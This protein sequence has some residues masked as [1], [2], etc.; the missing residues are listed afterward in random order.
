MSDTANWQLAGLTSHISL[1]HRPYGPRIHL[2]DTAESAPAGIEPAPVI[3][4][5][6]LEGDSFSVEEAF[7][8]YQNKNNPPADGA[9]DATAGNE[10]AEANPE[11]PETET[12]AEDQETEPAKPAIDPP[13]S[14]T[15]DLHDH[16]ATL[17]PALQE[18][19]V[20]RDREDQ[21]AI[22]RSF[23][24]AAEARKAAEAER[25]QAEQ[26]RKKYEEKL[27]LLEKKLQTVGPFADVQSMEDLR[28]MQAEDPFRF[29]QYQLYQWEQQAEQAELKEAEGRK[30][31]ERIGK[32][33]AYEAE[34]NKLLADLV[35]EMAD[36]KKVGQM[37]DDA[38]KMLEN[39][40]GLKTDLLQR[41]MNDDVGH[42]ILSNAGF[43][44][45]VADQLKAKAVKAAPP[46]AI[47]KPVPAVVKP[48]IAAPRGAQAAESVQASRNKLSG[49]GSVE[50][51]FA[52]YQA[53]RRR[54]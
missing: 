3:S 2:S 53:K 33:G 18:H 16:W 13:K 35:P 20:T 28:K 11:S 26:A 1:M 24:E 17:D 4:A 39:D 25:A 19:I 41:W 46:K 37:R 15:K 45:L 30:L 7:A 31:Q 40:F 10:L 9:D 5:P 54:S 12:T 47:P 49:S 29:Q 38:V 27:P 6:N 43:Q 21:A 32:R 48:G 36:P 42:E 44:K 14:W 34:Q 52:L 51:A 22:K 50:D 8:S 23:N